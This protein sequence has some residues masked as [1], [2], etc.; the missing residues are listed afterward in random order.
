MLESNKLGLPRDPPPLQF[1]AVG[2]LARDLPGEVGDS[3]LQ[4]TCK[5][6]RE[7]DTHGARP[8]MAVLR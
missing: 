7:A 8:H 4:G 1:L 5:G 6:L 3:S 2:L